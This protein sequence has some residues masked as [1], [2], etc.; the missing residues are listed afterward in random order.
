LRW[1]KDSG[2]QLS[3][4]HV[5]AQKAAY[6]INANLWRDIQVLHHGH[7]YDSRV[8]KDVLD[9]Y[10]DVTLQ[11]FQAPPGAAVVLF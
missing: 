11:P 5:P 2:R 10:R 9:I 4:R 6:Q 3:L 1:L 8:V 7:L